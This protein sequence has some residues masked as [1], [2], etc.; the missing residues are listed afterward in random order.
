MTLVVRA[1][2]L[3]V[4]SVVPGAGWGYEIG[5]QRTDEVEITFRSGED[6]EASFHASVQGGDL[7]V[8]I[9]PEEGESP[10]D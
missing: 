4:E 10:D 6:E 3:A 5:D 1:G 2:T 7:R 9:E 8:E